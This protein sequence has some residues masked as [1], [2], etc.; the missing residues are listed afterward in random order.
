MPNG[1]DEY[2]TTF[3]PEIPS[4]VLARHGARVL[5]P[6]I[7][8]AWP[9]DDNGRRLGPTPLPTVY[10]PNLLFATGAARAG[11]DN[12]DVLNRILE[13][14]GMRI[15]PGQ[16]PPPA[17]AETS[18]P[19]ELTPAPGR[20]GVVDAWHALVVIR[21][22]IDTN[23]ELAH[24]ISAHRDGFQLSHLLFSADLSIFG[25]PGPYQGTGSDPEFSSYIRAPE[26][27]PIPVKVIAPPPPRRPVGDGLPRRP[28]V[29]V[30]DSGIRQHPWLNWPPP[31]TQSHDGFVQFLQPLQQSVN[32][33]EHAPATESAAD[34]TVAVQDFPVSS[35]P[36]VGNT[37]PYYGHG[38]FITG[39]LRQIA[40]DCQV[41]VVRVMGS[42][43][44]VH[45]EDLLVALTG[46]R[47]RVRQAQADND[48]TLMVDVVSLSLGY[49]HELDNI[50]KTAGLGE[51]LVDLTEMGVLI[52]AAAGN[53]A[54][55]RKFFPAALNVPGMFSVGAL[56]P[57]GTRALFSN[58]GGWVKY[59]RSGAGL[60]STMPTDLQAARQAPVAPSNR[61]QL[62]PRESIDPDNFGGGFA[63]WDGTSFAAPI[64][65]GQLANALMAHKGKPLDDVSED[66][67]KDR[68]AAL[69]EALEIVDVDAVDI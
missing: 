5:D 7:A 52:A 60:V 14:A 51:I 46:I 33:G 26:P 50:S 49:F 58:G 41:L 37:D 11:L 43:G 10:Q 47:D 38:T 54:T 34:P 20:P 17:L 66:A 32:A 23:A 40:P 69:L 15:T 57:A 9:T 18:R 68:A 27:G 45:E 29:A 31:N 59:W 25:S 28:V 67:T 35:F 24:Q 12:W 36:L 16:P 13:R 39:I 3:V 30:I 6:A 65:A 42:D 19:V 53:H 62:P 22:A 64:V 21:H 8:T 61:E 48:P 44:V 56:N 4:S 1:E 55:A 63:V 2:A